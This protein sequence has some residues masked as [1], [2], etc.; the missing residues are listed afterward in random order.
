MSAKGCSFLVAVRAQTSLV[1]ETLS[2]VH[3]DKRVACYIYDLTFLFLLSQTVETS[4]AHNDSCKIQL[5]TDATAQ[6]NDDDDCDDDCDV[7]SSG[8]ILPK[9]LLF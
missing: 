2:P 9:M 3:A 7:T 1:I 8:L 5:Q 4:E 6:N